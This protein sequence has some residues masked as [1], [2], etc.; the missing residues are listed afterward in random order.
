MGLVYTTSRDVAPVARA[1]GEVL[2]YYI[3]YLVRGEKGMRSDSY[4][5]LFCTNRHGIGVI[6]DGSSSVR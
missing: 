3:V 6:M 1:R 4:L 5:G 2:S